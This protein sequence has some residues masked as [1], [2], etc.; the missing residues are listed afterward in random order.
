MAGT[1]DDMDGWK[2]SLLRAG[3]YPVHSEESSDS[4]V[5]EGVGLGVWLWG[6]LMGMWLVLVRRYSCK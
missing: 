4:P 6:L 1:E 5:S 3:V 2:A